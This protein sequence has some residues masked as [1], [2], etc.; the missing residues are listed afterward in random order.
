MA[1]DPVRPSLPGAVAGSPF[2]SQKCPVWVRNSTVTRPTG[3]NDQVQR[4]RGRALSLGT[5]MLLVSPQAHAGSSWSCLDSGDSSLWPHQL[6]SQAE[7]GARSV[8]LGQSGLQAPGREP[9]TTGHLCTAPDQCLRSA[10]NRHIHVSCPTPC[11]D[12]GVRGAPGLTVGLRSHR[13]TG[14]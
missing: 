2:Q 6:V 4:W 10:H 8:L 11:F 13:P 5:Y 1:R 3:P 14:R 12:V 7:A 9:A